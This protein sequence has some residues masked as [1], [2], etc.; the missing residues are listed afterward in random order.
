MSAPLNNRPT[1]LRDAF[2][3]VGSAVSFI[4]AVVVTLVSYG[5]LS[6]EQGTALGLLVNA[7]PGVITLVVGVLASFGVARKAEALVTPVS[8]PAALVQDEDGFTKLVSLVPAE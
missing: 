3:S 6:D 2:K 5:L 4:G 7:V 8:D 1:P